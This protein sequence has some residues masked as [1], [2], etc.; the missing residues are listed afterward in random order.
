MTVHKWFANKDCHGE[1]LY[2]RHGEIAD[3]VNALL[4]AT[5]NSVSNNTGNVSSDISIGCSVKFKA[6]AVQ[7]NGKAINKIYVNEVYKVSELKGD[8]AVLTL[9][10]SIIYAVNINNII[11][12]GATGGN[13]TPVVSK[14]SFLVKV[15]AD[16]LNV[17]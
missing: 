13:S 11:K 16:A 6:G 10:G 17:S 12:V 4:G 3:K 1:W 8:R 9:K 15:K 14:S 2:S 5:S 7:Y